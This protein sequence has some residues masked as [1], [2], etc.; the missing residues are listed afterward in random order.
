MTGARMTGQRI[1][2]LEAL[3][4]RGRTV[5][6]HD[7]HRIAAVAILATSSACGTSVYSNPII[8]RVEDSAQ[9]LGVDSVR[10]SAFDRHMGYSEDWAAKTMRV[11]TTRTP[12]STVLTTMGA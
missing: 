7:L 12:Y 1:D 11:A 5:R 10:V 6:L 8:I 3:S 2:G 9:R 4:Y